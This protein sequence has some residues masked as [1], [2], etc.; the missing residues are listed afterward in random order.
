MLY[1]GFCMVNVK[2]KKLTY[3]LKPNYWIDYHC[4]CCLEIIGT[5]KYGVFKNKK[6]EEI[7]K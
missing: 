3:G 7:K 5:K 1:C 2:P 4:P 6:E